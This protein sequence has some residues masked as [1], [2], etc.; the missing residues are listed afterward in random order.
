MIIDACMLFNEVDMLELRLNV[1]DPIVDAFVIVEAQERFGSDKGKPC[2]LFDNWD[3]FENFRS[4]IT[5][6]ILPTLCP[7]YVDV[8]SGWQ[9]EKYQRE[10]LSSTAEMVS[11]SPDDIL[12]C[13]DVD[14]IPNPDVLSKNLP[15]FSKSIH[16]LDLDFFYYNVNSYVGKWA[17]GTTVGTMSEYAKCGGSHQARANGYH[18][19]NRVVPDAGWHFSYFGDTQRILEK[20]SSFSHSKDQI[21]TDLINRSEDELKEDI[22]ERRDLFRRADMNQFEHR[23][24]DDPR[25]PKYFLENKD[26]F[27]H[28]VEE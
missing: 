12:L 5:Y 2:Y 22:R 9:R 19:T 16:R 21:V 13:S 3:R 18:D 6:M 14:E 26:K 28:F 8:A 20:V 23:S 11:T 15:A 27:K 10:H 17:W 25:L 24:S 1:L 4:K 7:S